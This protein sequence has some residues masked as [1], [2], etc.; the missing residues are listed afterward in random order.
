MTVSPE[1]GRDTTGKQDTDLRLLPGPAP[2][3]AGRNWPYYRPG[4]R[5]TDLAVHLS[6]DPKKGRSQDRSGIHDPLACSLHAEIC[7]RTSRRV[8]C[9]Q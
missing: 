6:G 2:E 8:L 5:D 7:S 1:T 3:L 4:D 9:R